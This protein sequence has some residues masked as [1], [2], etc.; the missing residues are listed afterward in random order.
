MNNKTVLRILTWWVAAYSGIIAIMII[1]GIGSGGIVFE[2]S[3][4]KSMSPFLSWVWL[5]SVPIIS[6]IAL[7]INRRIRW[8]PDSFVHGIML[9]IWV[10]GVVLL[11]WVRGSGYY[12]W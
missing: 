3:C 7:V 5:V 10:S 4:L 1:A 6:T 11:L 9:L 8:K 12:Y 2:K